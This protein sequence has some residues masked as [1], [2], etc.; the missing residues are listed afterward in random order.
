MTTKDV[1]AGLAFVLLLIVSYSFLE[2]FK[3]S[4]DSP[5][6]KQ[7]VEQGQKA[8]G[9]IEWGSDV[10]DSI[11]FWLVLIG[12]VGGVLYYLRKEGYL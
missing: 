10:V 6:G 11:E 2:Q 5:A 12:I 8:L 4:I 9:F 3:Q 1:I 7:A